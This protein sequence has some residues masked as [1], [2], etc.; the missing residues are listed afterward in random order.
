MQMFQWNYL[1]SKTRNTIT[2]Y[3]TPLLQVIDYFWSQQHSTAHRHTTWGKRAE[4]ELSMGI[5]FFFLMTGLPKG[6]QY[7]NPNKL[8]PRT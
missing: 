3:S 7:L 8:F 1:S 6:F 2:P 5:F 4:K